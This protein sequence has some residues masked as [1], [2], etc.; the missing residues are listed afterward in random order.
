MRLPPRWVVAVSLAVAAAIL[1]DSLL[2]A[3]LPTRY[4]D[5]G[6]EVVQ[7]GV[8]LSA[9]RFIRLASNPLAGWVMARLGP[10]GP[11]LVSVFVAAATTAAY[12]L[13]LGFAALLA[14]RALWGVCWSFLR[15]GG[16]LAALESSDD[17][18]RGYYL[19]FF[20]GVTRFGSFVAVLAGG[21][22]TDLIGFDAT[23][24]T[25]TA[26]TVLGGVAVL[27]EHPPRAVRK[28]GV[29]VEAGSQTGTGTPADG[30]DA[31]S[32]P[33][34]PRTGAPRHALSGR[35]VLVYAAVFLHG[36]AVSGLTTATLGLWLQSLYG[37]TAPVL[38]ISVGVA[39]L[40][41]FLLSARFLADFIWGPL[42]GHLS[43]RHGRLRLT[44][45]AGL[46][47]A[48]ALWG[49][50][51][52]GSLAATIVS[53]VALFLAA[54]ALQSA[55]DATAGDLAPPAA[56]SRT[57]SWYATCLDL[58][59]AV[60]PLAGYYLIEAGLGPDLLYRATGSLVVLM[61]LVYLTGFRGRAVESGRPAGPGVGA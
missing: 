44:L 34:L 55:L 14:A 23:V 13:G 41:G 2:Y 54:T 16:Y 5:V 43:D 46:I 37:P 48:A 6:I 47:E 7:V 51:Q 3:V 4:G 38:W 8:L 31:T 10:R 24:Y 58:G 32:E 50:A 18:N 39:T 57:M 27:R 20:N 26:L 25:F 29:P 61:G 17:R 15:L 19:G 36:L 59:A 52:G 22:L 42:S 60:G 53:A 33:L 49:L 28:A 1:G 9:N 12:A 21:L 45:I 56:R 11:F 40:T 35:I 30:N